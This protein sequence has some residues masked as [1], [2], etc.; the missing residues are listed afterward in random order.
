M[1]DYSYFE[2][3]FKI[4][5]PQNRKFF[6]KIYI[7]TNNENNQALKLINNVYGFN[8]EIVVSEAEMGE[9]F[10]QTKK[11]LEMMH[12][13]VYVFFLQPGMILP[14]NFNLLLG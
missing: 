2:D 10:K 13:N 9:A 14:D 4:E 3:F 12:E 11:M 6:Q 7:I 1:T 5:F 8:I